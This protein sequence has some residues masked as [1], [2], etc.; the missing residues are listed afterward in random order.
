MKRLEWLVAALLVIIGLCCLT[1]SGTLLIHP[2]SIQSYVRTFLK[3]CGWMGLPI[4]VTGI[5]YVI[6]LL[7]N[8]RRREN[9]R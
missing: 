2:D 3:I 6:W 5:I 1:F 4:V 7:K 8:K 9:R